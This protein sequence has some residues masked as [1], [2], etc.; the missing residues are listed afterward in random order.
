[1][2]LRLLNYFLH[3]AKEES[4]S[5][6]AHSLGITQP[7]LS[8]QLRDLEQELG[9]ILF[10]RGA[11]KIELTEEGLLLKRRA[12]EILSLTDLTQEEIRTFRQQLSGTVNIGV[13]PF[14][15]VQKL[16][17]WI[18]AF[19][20]TNPQVLFSLISGS[21][22]TLLEKAEQ[23]LLDGIVC[24]TDMDPEKWNAVSLKD[25]EDVH[26]WIA[27]GSPLADRFF[28]TPQDLHQTPLILPESRDIRALIE[29]WMHKDS[30]TIVA[31]LAS[32]QSLMADLT[33][34]RIGAGFGLDNLN[35]ALGETRILQPELKLNIRLAW[36][37]DQPYGRAAQAFFTFLTRQN[38]I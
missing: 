13:H 3:V 27:N 26:L 36:Q 22:D 21:W 6:A 16:G 28:I 4:I 20:Q 23:G 30:Q 5:A 15:S 7:T 24:C 38:T 29:N 14:L 12:E 35:P 17:D 10:V 33:A 19:Q 9:T 18:H 2:E 37:K 1:M 31:A 11:R 25:E 8:R 32:N 34:S